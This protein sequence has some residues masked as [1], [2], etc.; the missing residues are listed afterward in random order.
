[1]PDL[2]VPFLDVGA[3]YRELQPRIHAA[4]RRVL[5]SGWFVLGPEVEAFE[6]AYASFCGTRHAIGMSNGLD[7]LHLTLRA[8][9]IGPGDEVLVPGN[10]FVATWLA[11][12]YAG[13]VPVGIDPLPTANMDPDATAAAIG[14]RTAAIVPVHLY[15]QPADMPALRSIADRHGLFLVEDAAQAHGA[16]YD[17]QPA[18]SL[19]HAG[20][21]SFYPGKNL[22]AF[23]D[24][25][26]VT[27]DD[28]QLAERIRA[29][30]NYGS[31][32][33]YHHDVPGFNARLDA[34]QAA[35]LD[36]KLE[37]LSS[38]NQRRAAIASRYDAAFADLAD[39]EPIARDPRATSSWHLYVVRHPRR[40]ALAASLARS[41]VATQVHYPVPCHRTPAC[42][43]DVSLPVSE[44]MAAEVLSLPIGPHLTDAQVTQ[45]IDA[46]QEACGAVPA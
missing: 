44:Q 7:A 8:A 39:V 16:T 30:R 46:V 13:A 36:V 37:A 43:T 23:G 38:W 3:T 31:A 6:A 14:P 17:Q 26:A 42:A 25:G 35:I 32:V 29:L 27:T 2:T 41:G 28:P 9:G 19:G 34:I 15:G 40:D 12:T 5:E 10:T 24:G 21:F 4:M 33:K 20:S 22:G 45:V 11:V 18:G 1:M